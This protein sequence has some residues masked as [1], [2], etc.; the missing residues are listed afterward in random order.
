MEKLIKLVGLMHKSPIIFN[1]AVYTFFTISISAHS[2]KLHKVIPTDSITLDARYYIELNTLKSIAVDLDASSPLDIN[3]ECGEQTCQSLRE[4]HHKL[5]NLEDDLRVYQNLLYYSIYAST[6]IFETYAETTIANEEFKNK[7][8]NRLIV[9]E[10]IAQFASLLAD[11]PSIYDHIKNGSGPLPKK[12]GDKL[13][14]LLNKA[15]ANL[16]VLNNVVK[17]A[18]RD[19]GTDAVTEITGSQNW[20]NVYA[21]LKSG[22]DALVLNEH[23]KTLVGSGNATKVQYSRARAGVGAL[24]FRLL[25]VWANHEQQLMR[26]SIGELDEYLRVNQHVYQQHYQRKVLK[27]SIYD[28]IDTLKTRVQKQ[29]RNVECSSR[30]SREDRKDFLMN[31]NTFGAGLL[32]YKEKIVNAAADHGLVWKSPPCVTYAHRFSVRDGVG[33]EFPAEIKVEQWTGTNSNR[34]KFEGIANGN[35]EFMLLPTTYLLRIPQQTGPDQV[36]KSDIILWSY[37]IPDSQKQ[38]IKPNSASKDS[39]RQIT[40]KPYGRVQLEVFDPQGNP[41]PFSYTISKGSKIERS[42]TYLGK[43]SEAK[44]ETTQPVI[45]DLPAGDT[46]YLG[47]EDLKRIL[48]PREVKDFVLE[49]GKLRK[50]SYTLYPHPYK[51]TIMDG[52]GKP[53]TPYINIARVSDGHVVYDGPSK[54]EDIRLAPGNYKIHIK[55]SIDL[56]FFRVSEA[57]ISYHNISSYDPYSITLN[58]YGR[59]NL[60]VVD[61]VGNPID[62]GYAFK[63]LSNGKTIASSLTAQNKTVTT[64]LQAGVELELE[65][66]HAF[67]SDTKEVVVVPGKINQLKYVYDK[68]KFYETPKKVTDPQPLNSKPNSTAKTLKEAPAGW[69]K[70]VLYNSNDGTCKRYTGLTLE[71]VNRNSEFFNL[72]TGERSERILVP[73]GQQVQVAAPN[74]GGHYRV[75][76]VEKDGSKN[77]VS[78]WYLKRSVDGWWFAAGCDDGTKPESSNCFNG[79]DNRGGKSY[80][81][82][83]TLGE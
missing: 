26:E 56:S 6:Q 78:F 22:I 61:Q 52:V 34:K 68:R 71:F 16:T 48:A 47:L 21:S 30:F 37:K 83:R 33:K 8:Q 28:Y 57:T 19:G 24:I 80:S 12:T 39:I 74:N 65:L 49:P 31:K 15:D 77:T 20:S 67:D 41:M 29:M 38:V 64:D 54:S 69:A 70:G 2:A 59:I 50:F 13:V 25:G 5:Y 60:D 82:C 10:G 32:Y 11:I 45:L 76:V 14:Q 44:N 51:F 23:F 58:P 53:I 4:Y 66:I 72:E 18:K 63:N 7:L 42:T 35:K 36:P 81:E 40:V 46:L 9:K 75:Q 17:V 43:I 27:R 73:P 1:L 55:E 3:D 62:F 79:I